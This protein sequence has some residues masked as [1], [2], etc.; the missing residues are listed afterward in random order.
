[1]TGLSIA[2]H[3]K[4]VKGTVRRFVKREYSELDALIDKIRAHESHT[5]LLIHACDIKVHAHLPLP[6]KIVSYSMK[7]ICLIT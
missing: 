5:D 3:I 1:M 4:Q 7:L 6:M 2:Q